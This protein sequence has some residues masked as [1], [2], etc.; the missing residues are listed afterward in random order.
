MSLVGRLALIA[1]AILLAALGAL[2]WI[3]GRE[4]ASE[5]EQA[6][7]ERSEAVA[8]SLALQL[9]RVLQYGLPLH[10]IVGFEEQ[11][12]QAVTGNEG[13]EY[14]MVLGP[15]GIPL[16]IH[17]Q[18][19]ARGQALRHAGLRD[20]DD[21]EHMHVESLVSLP[22]QRATAVVRIGYRSDLVLNRLAAIERNAVAGG[23]AIFALGVLALVAALR[24]LVTRPLARISRTMEQI[25]SG[26]SLQ[27]R[28]PE[29][30]PREFRALAASFNAMV[31]E[32]QAQSAALRD[33]KSQ[34]DGANQAKSLFLAKMSHEIRTPINGVLGMME[35]LLRTPLEP[36]QKRFAKAAARS[37]QALMEI[38]NDLLDYSKIEAGHLAL[39]QVPFNLREVVQDT[40]AVLEPNAVAKGLRLDYSVA[41]ELPQMLVGDPLRVRQIV[42]NLLS[43]AIKFTPRGHAAVR[44][45]WQAG[46]VRIEVSDTGIGMTQQTIRQVV[47]PFAQADNSLTRPYG[48]TGLG[49]TIARELAESMGGDLQIESEP[50]R[51]S[52][53]TVRLPLPPAQVQ[54]P[55][56]HST[57][58]SVLPSELALMARDLVRGPARLLIVDDN[59]LN[60]E[61]LEAMLDGQGYELH[62]AGSGPAALA[63]CEASRFDLVLMDCAM[64]GMDGYQTTQELRR[65][66]QARGAAPVPVIAVTGNAALNARERCVAAGMNDYLSKPCPRERLLATVRRWLEPRLELDPV[67]NAAPVP[68]RDGIDPLAIAALRQLRQP[69]GPDIVARSLELFERNMAR[70]LEQARNA[71]ASGSA[72]ALERAA[73]AIASS[74]YGVGAVSI[75]ELA[76]EL[77]SQARQGLPAD[78]GDQVEAIAGLLPGALHTLRQL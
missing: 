73:N 1:T 53:F 15:D 7:R 28:M 40:L 70:Q 59:E 20:V 4:F 2:S 60:R 37:G 14:A 66:E 63:A 5:L 45:D 32:L 39:E 18:P 31:A 30:G 35:M 8:R 23:L 21:K 36:R 44:L 49:L 48:G 22:G 19:H 6:H 78:A 42:W 12:Q 69:D 50:G 47:E 41:P 26:G 11:L 10:E 13:F 68:L 65:R 46:Q 75:G 51:G 72:V 33:A 74:A 9:E 64:P 76:R 56:E 24:V 52:L 77:E 29:T 67:A 62:F 25:R 71:C 27:L 16:F 38:I 55:S 58:P 61:V 54:P 34:A 3:G 57:P 17:E 43:N